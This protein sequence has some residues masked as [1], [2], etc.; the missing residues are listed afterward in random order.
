ML[1]HPR[2]ILISFLI[3]PLNCYE[4][5]TTSILDINE[6]SYHT[7]AKYVAVVLFSLFILY[8]VFSNVLMAVVFCNRSSSYSRSFILITSQLIICDLLTFLSVIVVLPKILQTENGS[9]GWLFYSLI[10]VIII[11]QDL[12]YLIIHNSHRIQF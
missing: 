12:G 2:F 1:I 6:D 8:G 11:N 10:A 5:N 3:L 7:F 9:D 4:R